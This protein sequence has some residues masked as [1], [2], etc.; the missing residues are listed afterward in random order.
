M[1]HPMK[2]DEFDEFDEYPL[3]LINLQ[4][5]LNRVLPI[6][7]KLAMI[8]EAIKKHCADIDRIAVALYDQ[9]TDSLSTFI[10]SSGT[11]SPLLNY[12]V[13]LREVGSLQEIGKSGRPRV[14]NDLSA[15]AD[16]KGTHTQKV[17]AQGY[18]SSA[19]FPLYYDEN[20]QGFLFFNSYRKN[21]FT[22]AVFGWL[23]LFSHII[24]ALIIKET[25]VIRTTTAAVR[26]IQNITRHKDEETG[27]HMERVS[28]YSRLIA[29]GL[30]GKYGFSDE[31][32]EYIALFS[33]MHDIGKIVIPDAILG[34]P[35]KLTPEEFAIIKTH[36]TKGR[37]IIDTM[38]REFALGNFQ[39]II[40]LR[41][42]VEFHHEAIDGSGYP[43]GLKGDEIPVEAR[44]STVA[45]IFDALTSRRPYK[46][47]WSNEKAFATL[48]EMAGT[49]LDRDCVEVFVGNTKGIV[50]IQQCFLDENHGKITGR[51]R[52]AGN[53][54]KSKS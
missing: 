30:A 33:P 31:F 48:R 38:M 35:G 18:H 46:E 54:E 36:S 40:M 42:I 14:L 27:S 32:I 1:R 17:V 6:G 44:I 16:G 15:L 10:H 49:K 11:D 53:S 20:I 22:P 34:K 7:Q 47:P 26:T 3:T 24:S 13:K 52:V 45:D 41:N 29:L 21:V 37:E 39:H 9:K 4:K 8:H 5:E 43:L 12:S 2:I 23:V 50:E 28:H 25:S 19:T 51:T